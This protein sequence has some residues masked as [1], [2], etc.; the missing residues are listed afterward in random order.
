MKLVLKEDKISK[1]RDHIEKGSSLTVKE[2]EVFDRYFFAF[3][4]LLD[5]LS[6]RQVVELLMMYPTPIGGLSQSMA[7]NVVNGC[8]A[9]CGTG[10]WENLYFVALH[11]LRGQVVATGKVFFSVVDVQT[12]LRYST[13]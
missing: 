9:D 4:Q 11:R 7:Y 5:G 1:Y 2:K 12:N 10:I 8:N 3:S 13:C 6:E